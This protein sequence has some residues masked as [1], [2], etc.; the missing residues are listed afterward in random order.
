MF[1]SQTL[2]MK[3]V[4]GAKNSVRKLPD[5]PMDVINEYIGYYCNSLVSRGY[6]KKS[7]LMRGYCL[8]PAGK[9]AL[10]D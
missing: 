3:S 4:A 1:P 8:T 7:G 10:M 6:L 2:V 9:K 5:R